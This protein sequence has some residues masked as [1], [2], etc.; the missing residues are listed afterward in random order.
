MTYAE[1]DFFMS[2]QEYKHHFCYTIFSDIKTVTS[3]AK[4]AQGSQKLAVYFC[5]YSERDI[6]S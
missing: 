6:F 5:H 2:I 3:I 1:I 4:E